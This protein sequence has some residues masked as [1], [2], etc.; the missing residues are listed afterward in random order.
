MPAATKTAAPRNATR[1]R[2]ASRGDTTA[3]KTP[4]SVASAAAREAVDSESESFSVS[5]DH[6][7][8]A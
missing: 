8:R 7:G 5:N 1:P 4:K 3:A 2:R 6:A